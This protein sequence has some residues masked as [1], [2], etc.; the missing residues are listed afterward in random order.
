MGMDRSCA[1][2]TLDQFDQRGGQHRSRFTVLDDASHLKLA[3]LIGAEEV[4]TLIG[5]LKGG[6]E[7]DQRQRAKQSQQEAN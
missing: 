4:L 5:H 2:E 6:R 1:Q 7:H 3:Q